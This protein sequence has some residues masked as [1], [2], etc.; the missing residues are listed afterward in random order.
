MLCLQSH[1]SIWRIV[2]SFCRVWAVRFVRAVQEKKKQPRVWLECAA[3]RPARVNEPSATGCHRRAAKER[4]SMS[5]ERGKQAAAG[6]DAQ[7]LL[8]IWEEQIIAARHYIIGAR[9]RRPDVARF[10]IQ[11]VHFMLLT[12]REQLIGL[13][14]FK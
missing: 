1:S 3:P 6:N 2:V 4:V 14:E 9:E 5:K 8:R 10:Q 12:L 7:F 11:G 13:R